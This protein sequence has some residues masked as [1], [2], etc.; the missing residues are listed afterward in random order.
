MSIAA[1]LL[2]RNK[3]LGKCCCVRVNTVLIVVVIAVVCLAT[4][5]SFILAKAEHE[6]YE[7]SFLNDEGL[8]NKEKT[9]RRSDRKQ[10]ETLKTEATLSVVTD[11]S[12]KIPSFHIVFSTGCNAFQDCKFNIR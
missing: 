7:S 8:S 3:R 6:R 11:T 9:N 12:E 10:L 4:M 2:S 1:I 5:K